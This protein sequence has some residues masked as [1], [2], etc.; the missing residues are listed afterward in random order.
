MISRISQS[1]YILLGNL[2][3]DYNLI[4][5]RNNSASLSIHAR[6]LIRLSLNCHCGF[7]S[8]DIRA[9]RIIQSIE[10]LYKIAKN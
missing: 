6:I 7:I 9:K 3:Y 5:L 2:F 8:S 10:Y 4:I 1:E